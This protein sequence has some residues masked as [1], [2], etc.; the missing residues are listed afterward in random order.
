MRMPGLKKRSAEASEDRFRRLLDSAKDK[1]KK[2]K[3][4]HVTLIESGGT[5]E[6]ATTGYIPWFN[7]V[8]DNGDLSPWDLLATLLAKDRICVN[9][10]EIEPLLEEMYGEEEVSD[11]MGD[12]V[13]EMLRSLEDKIISTQMLRDAVPAQSFEQLTNE[14]IV[15]TE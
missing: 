13:E 2:L 9:L 7:T 1:G 3:F 10:C 12:E 8:P 4:T 15:Q 6:D 5:A 14:L 11:E